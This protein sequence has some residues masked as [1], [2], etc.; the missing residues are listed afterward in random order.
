MIAMSVLGLPDGAIIFLSAAFFSV[1]TSFIS[2]K[3]G[4]KQK[5]DSIQKAMKD[6]QKEMNEAVKRD[7]KK[8]LEELKA[9][10]PEVMKMMNEM[11]FLPFKNMIFVI[12]LFLIFMEVVNGTFRGF[13]VDLPI[14]LHLNGNELLGLNIFKSSVYGPRG[15]FILSSIVSGMVIEGVWGRM[16]KK[17]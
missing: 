5:T 2:R 11:M 4:I 6:Y 14:A 13:L 1:I 15:F 3:T 12:P 16:H 9:R 8:R 10:E 7:D 17:T